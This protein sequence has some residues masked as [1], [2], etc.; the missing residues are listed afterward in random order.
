MEA[1]SGIQSL[2]IALI[3]ALLALL[4][5]VWIATGPLT[6]A[7]AATGQYCW[8]VNTA[9]WGECGSTYYRYLVAV[10]AKGGQ[11]AA[12]TSAQEWLQL[13]H[14]WACAGKNEW[15][16]VNFNGARELGGVAKNNTGNYN[17]L[18]GEMWW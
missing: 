4:G 10:F 6:N 3:A 15:A 16:Q 2:R 17:V 12:C 18:Y 11:G 5:T 14:P 1:R 8:G 13:V 9:P 7:K